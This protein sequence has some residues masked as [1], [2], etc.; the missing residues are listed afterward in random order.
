MRVPGK[1]ELHREILPPKK[2]KKKKVKRVKEGSGLMASTGK[3]EAREPLCFLVH[4]GLHSKFQDSKDNIETL[5]EGRGS[6]I[7]TKLRVPIS[8]HMLCVI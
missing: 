8:Y 4:P 5:G 7:D 3:V 2:K 6:R 1:P